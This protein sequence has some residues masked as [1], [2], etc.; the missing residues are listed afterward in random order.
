MRVLV[1]CEMSGTVR[2]AFARRGHYAVSADLQLCDKPGNHHWGDVMEILYHDWDL[3]IAHPPCTYLCRLTGHYLN[4]G[5]RSYRGELRYRK[6]IAAA[7]FFKKFL[8]HPCSQVAVENPVMSRFAAAA[9]GRGPDQYVEPFMFG[10]SFSKKTGLWL[11]GLPQ[12]VPTNLVEP[13]KSWVEVN[14]RGVSRRIRA[15][16]NSM[17][18]PGIAEAMAMQWG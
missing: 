10:H 16:R 14:G 7:D 3:V 18:F 1:A 15:V 17:T 12:L 2:D 6:M 13:K 5:S 11:K 8:S 9:V 4:P